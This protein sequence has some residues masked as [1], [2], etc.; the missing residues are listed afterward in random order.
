[1]LSDEDDR[2]L[3][4]RHLGHQCNKSG[5]SDAASFGS[6]IFHPRYNTPV[7]EINNNEEDDLVQVVVEVEQVS[8]K[9]KN[10]H[11]VEEARPQ[12]HEGDDRKWTVQS[13]SSSLNERVVDGRSMEQGISSGSNIQL[14]DG[15]T[16]SCDPSLLGSA[17][18]C[19][20]LKR[21]QPSSRTES[22][23]SLNTVSVSVPIPFRS[24]LPLKGHFPSYEILPG[25]RLVRPYSCF[26]HC[27][28]S[29][30]F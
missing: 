19:N 14:V 3:V 15:A 26:F 28:A 30:T 16:Q 17:E 7:S 8:E 29:H 11:H 20:N 5:M 18:W 13:H 1:M 9:M 27:F 22:S 12:I 23:C 4:Q 21:C 25:G 6:S 2:L 10:G 24:S